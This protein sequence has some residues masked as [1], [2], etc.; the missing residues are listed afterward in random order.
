MQTISKMFGRPPT[1]VL[2]RDEER[3]ENLLSVIN[4]L[5]P[6]LLDMPFIKL[7]S[8]S[9]KDIIFNPGEFQAPVS[10]KTFYGFPGDDKVVPLDNIAEDKNESMKAY[11]NRSKKMPRISEE[12]FYLKHYEKEYT[13]QYVQNFDQPNSVLNPEFS[14]FQWTQAQNLGI[15]GDHPGINTPWLF[16]GQSKSLFPFHLE[17]GNLQSLNI[18]L[19]GAP[20]LWF[21]VRNADIDK[22]EQLLRNSQEA[23]HCPAFFRHKR[24]FIDLSLF[25]DN[26]IPIYSC[27]QEPGDIIVTNSFH[28]GVNLGFNVNWAVNIFGGTPLEYQRARN[29]SHC[30][31]RPGCDYESKSNPMNRVYN[32]DIEIKCLIEACQN[33]PFET[34]NSLKTHLRNVHMYELP[35]NTL[36][37]SCPICKLEFAQPDVHLKSH[38]IPF[39]YCGLCRISFENKKQLETHYK[40]EHCIKKDMKCKSCSMVAQDFNDVYDDHNCEIDSS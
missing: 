26:F 22:V 11:I 10:R 30:P 6:Y 8:T 37:G 16:L 25:H 18:M 24:H 13:F 14:N 32:L 31:S 36:I 21:G 7:H 39:V 33:K 23:V 35:K 20:K 17:D 40:L 5:E 38:I 28:Q 34:R 29:G 9:I 15:L 1:K 12:E 3:E 4:N 27:I 2:S 19:A